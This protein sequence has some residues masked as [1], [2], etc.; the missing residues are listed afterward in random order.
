MFHQASVK[1]NLPISFTHSSYPSQNVEPKVAKV[2]LQSVAR[3]AW[4]QWGGS[5]AIEEA[6]ILCHKSRKP[7][8]P[9]HASDGSP[10][11]AALSLL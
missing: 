2:A 8:K 6:G 4:W 10:A 7:G 11:K 3:V 9:Q 1:V 5:V